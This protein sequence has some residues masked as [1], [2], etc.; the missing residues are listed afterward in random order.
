MVGTKKLQKMAE[1]RFLKRD[2]S[3]DCITAKAVIFVIF[4]ISSRYA[5]DYS[6]NT[7]LVSH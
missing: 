7:A 4:N 2:E 3:P 5:E 1:I 6:D